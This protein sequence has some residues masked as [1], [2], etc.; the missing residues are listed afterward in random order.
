MKATRAHGR[1]A[2]AATGWTIAGA[3]L[4]LALPL[5]AP[6]QELEE[7]VEE[8]VMPQAT[9]IGAGG[10]TYQTETDIDGGGTLS[11]NRFDVAIASQHDLTDELRWTNLGY[12]GVDDYDFDGG[13]FSSGNPWETVLSLRL[14][15]KLAY[16]INEQWGVWGAAC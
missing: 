11:V 7:L 15:T 4:A 8:Q 1:R 3:L 12:F 16:R 6:A 14:G 10:Y 2:R 5:A 13:G 9:I